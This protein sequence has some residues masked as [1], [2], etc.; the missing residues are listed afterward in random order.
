MIAHLFPLPP[1]PPFG[2]A[3]CLAAGALVAAAVFFL[4]PW[5]A[6]LACIFL[7]FLSLISFLE[8][9]RALSLV[10]ASSVLLLLISSRDIPTTAFWTLVVLLVLF[11][12][13]SS[14]LIFLLNLLE[15][16]VQVSL[17][18]LIFW[19][20]RD[21]ALEETKKWTLPSLPANLEP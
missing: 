17:T 7:T 9:S 10:A 8:A 13:M 16:C 19:W 3:A 6:F 12:W 1:L 5:V 21:L 18:G 11:F 4:P 2:A 14:T 15:A 20:K